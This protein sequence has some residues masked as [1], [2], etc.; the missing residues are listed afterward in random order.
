MFSGTMRSSPKTLIYD[1]R[2]SL[3]KCLEALNDLWSA[4]RPA[5]GQSAFVIGSC[6]QG[7][8]KD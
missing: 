5:R 3:I 1:G 6:Q 4:L 2:G 7:K 8:P